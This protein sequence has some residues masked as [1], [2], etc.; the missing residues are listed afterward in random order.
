MVEKIINKGFVKKNLKSFFSLI[1]LTGL[2]IFSHNTVRGYDNDTHFWLTYYLAIKSGYTSLQATQIASATISVDFDKNSQPLIPRAISYTDFTNYM[3]NVRARLHALPLRSDINKFRGSKLDW[4]KEC[5]REENEKIQNFMKESVL[6]G[7]R[8]LWDEVKKNKDN[9][10]VFFHYLQDKYAHRNFRSFWGHACYLRIDFTDSNRPKAEDMAKETVFY[11]REFFKLRWSERPLPDLP[12]ENEIRRVINRLAEINKSNGIEPE[13]SPLL[14]ALRNTNFTNLKSFFKNL[15]QT[16]NTFN[17][18][19][20]SSKAR[21]IIAEELNLSNDQIPNIW[22]YNLD[23]YGKP[24]KN[25]TSQTACYNEF[26]DE[27]LDETKNLVEDNK[28]RND[29]KLK[30]IAWRV[31]DFN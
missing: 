9:P 10:G 2:L 4:K 19:P 11:L 5:E 17:Y 16:Y 14:I 15:K 1:V 24:E 29:K 31:S 22:L 20:D 26:S 27:Q 28:C 8:I 23:K 12:D 3:Q 13:P 21:S 7:Q 18:R 30:S 25:Q 6:Q